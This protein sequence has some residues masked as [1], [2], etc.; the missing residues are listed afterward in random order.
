VTPLKNRTVL[1]L[2]DIFDEGKTLKS[3]IQ[4][5]ESQGAT[6]IVSAV[7]LRKNHNRSVT[8]DSIDTA[9]SDNI[10]LTVEDKYVF[11]FGMDYNGQYRQLNSIYA[12]EED[13]R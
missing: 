7:L 3:I 11:G 5:C 2:D 9:L 13:N 4:Y 12:L 8:H 6:N 1:I 10:A